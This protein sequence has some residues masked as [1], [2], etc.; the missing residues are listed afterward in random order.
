MCMK[1][2]IVFLLCCFSITLGITQNNFNI[3]TYGAKA[4]QVTNDAPAIQAA[5]DACAKAG[6]GV[7]YIPP[8]D[9]L[10]SPL[11]LKSN[12]TLHIEAGATLWAHSDKSVYY[13]DGQVPMSNLTGNAEPHTD[14]D[15]INGENLENIS[16]TGKGTING[17]GPTYWWGK[18]KFRPYIL[19]IR[20]SK[21]IRF[22]DVTT[23]GSPTHTFAFV[24]SDRITIRGIALYNDPKSPNTDGIHL[25]NCSNIHISGIHMDTGDD[26]LVVGGGTTSLTVTNCTFVTPWALMWVIDGRGITLNNCV[27]QCQILLKDIQKAEYVTLANIVA[28]GRGRLFSMMGGPAKHITLS[29]VTAYDFAQA[30]WMENAENITLDNVKVIRRFGSGSAAI[31]DGF[32]FRKVKGLTLRNVEI[33]NIDNGPA[34]SCEEVEDM[35]LDGF[36]ASY[37]PKDQ[38]AVRLFQTRNAYLHECRGEPGTQFLQLEGEQTDNIRMV[39]NDLNSATVEAAESV[40]V[41]ALP[42]I[43][44]STSELTLPA[45]LQT[46]EKIPVSARL[47]NTSQLAGFSNARLKVNGKVTKNCWVW[48]N[49]GETKEV[50]LSAGPFYRQQDYQITINDLSSQKRKLSPKPAALDYLDLKADKEIVKAGSA[51]KLKG[52]LK[53]IGSVPAHEN[54]FLQVGARKVASKSVEIEPGEVIE[55]EFEYTAIKES[56]LLFS[57]DG[58]AK[59]TVKAY[60]ENRSSTILD[61]DFERA[62]DGVIYDQSGLG[63]HLYLRSNPGGTL[64]SVVKGKIGNGLRFNGESAYAEITGMSISYPMSISMWIKPGELT[65]S[66]IGGRQM[67]F[68]TSI[69]KGNDGFGPEDE[70]HIARGTGSHLVFWNRPGEH[71]ELRKKFEDPRQYYHLTIVYG[72]GS[73]SLYINGEEIETQKELKKLPDFSHYADRI[74]LGRPTVDYLRYFNGELDELCIFREALSAEEVQ[75]LY[76][77]YHN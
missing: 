73:A 40:P 46:N 39:N 45:T 49:G 51:I 59:C 12:I 22:E 60:S 53:N 9:Y 20:R 30:G 50:Q 77:S 42:A 25:F 14:Y 75:S 67:I 6:G 17:Q 34:L 47:S 52:R 70:T 13:S 24:E 23:I 2:P 16:I 15:L 61:L 27:V 56:L 74:Y 64:P 68:Y 66:S 28:S 7:V 3:K 26:C 55:V 65:P 72:R 19:R 38:P 54:I 35:E 62:V 43:K 5:I 37:F 32:E 58:Q 44:V 8:G 48:L 4:T 21:N 18:E 41:S 33:Q 76:E 31:Q 36:R 11:F 10:V 69:A 71:F 63:H 1:K 29:N 57:I